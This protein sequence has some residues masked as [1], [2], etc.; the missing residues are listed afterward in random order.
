MA[1]VVGIWCAGAQGQP[2]PPPNSPPDQP[3]P[4]KAPEP[5]PSAVESLKAEAE[6]L[7][8]LVTSDMAKRLLDAVASLPE[9]SPR[10]VHRHREKGTALTPEQFEPLPEAEREGYTSKE[11]DGRIF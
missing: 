10:V 11:Y 5:V 7:R 3:P 1:A 4:A 9:V 6:L 2:S 8:P